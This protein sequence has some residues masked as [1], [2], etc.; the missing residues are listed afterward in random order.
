MKTPNY[1]PVQALATLD[2]IITGWGHYTCNEA[3]IAELRGI[4]KSITKIL[5]PNTRME[6]LRKV[7]AREYS[8]T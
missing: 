1:T 8:A 6:Q 4:R 3:Q 2:S 5:D 7:D